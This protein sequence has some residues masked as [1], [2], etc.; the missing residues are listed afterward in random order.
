[1]WQG[2]SEF[3][4]S[5]ISGRSRSPSAQH[6]RELVLLYKHASA[7]RLDYLETGLIRFTQPHEFNDPFELKP[8]ISSI[9][10]FE[11]VAKKLRDSIPQI[12]DMYLGLPESTRNTV[13]LEDFAAQFADGIYMGTIETNLS[14]AEARE[15]IYKAFED[16]VGILSLTEIYVSLL[17]WAH[18]SDSHRGLVFGFDESHCF[19][20]QRRS[21]IDQLRYL[22]KVDYSDL[23]PQISNFDTQLADL[24]HFFVKSREWEYER[25]WRMVMQL[26]DADEKIQ[27]G[28]RRI[29]LY[30][31]PFEA[32]RSV[33]LGCRATSETKSRAI[34]LLSSS[35]FSHVRLYHGAICKDQFNLNFKALN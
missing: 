7:E 5:A 26:N 12:L 10:T 18:Y 31:I 23:R 32:L 4:L 2:L 3:L 28:S 16:Q 20:C 21:E 29:Y 33:Y 1:M 11:Y 6:L 25:E 27:D 14:T 15:T 19:F 8:A 13:T 17:M 24:N 22:R 30:S 9:M 35:R 34:A